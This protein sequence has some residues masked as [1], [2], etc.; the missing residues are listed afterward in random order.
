MS[1]V[2]HREEEGILHHDCT[3][4]PSSR[5]RFRQRQSFGGKQDALLERCCAI[6]SEMEGKREVGR[7]Q[8]GESAEERSSFFFGA[9]DAFF[10]FRFSFSFSLLVSFFCST[11]TSSPRT[12][13][14]HKQTNKQ[15]GHL[16][17]DQLEVVKVP[18]ADG[19]GRPRYTIKPI[20]DE[21]PFDKVG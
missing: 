6:A 13:H 21:L 3:L 16:L 17:K 20:E 18:A 15:Q 5:G 2:C 1:E 7:K 4:S 14:F 8:R 11:S 10:S 12:K 19:V 9:L